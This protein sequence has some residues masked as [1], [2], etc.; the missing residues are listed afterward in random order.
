MKIEKIVFMGTPDFAVPTLKALAD[1]GFKPLLCITQ[2]DRPKGRNR[3]PQA[4]PVKIAAEQLNIPVIQPEDVNSPGMINKLT[5]ISPDIIITVAYGGY[6]KREIR[7]LPAFGCINLHP[8]LLPKYRG[9]APINY[10]L[11]NGDKNTGNTIF[12]IAAKM[13]AGP[14]ISQNKIEIAESDCYTLLY[15]KLSESG[16]QDVVNVLQ[17][18]EQNEII[19]QEQDHTK[20]TFSHKLLK[21]DL[22]INWNNPAGNIRNKV[23]G[24][25]EVPG[26]TASFREKRIKIIEVK[27]L[28][29]L[30]KEHPGSILDISK[31]GIIVNTAD[32][33]MLIKK[34]QPAGKNIMTAHAFSLGARIET[35]EKIEDGF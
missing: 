34:V 15:K 19:F 16:A 1:T 23:R 28:D 24:L 4:T 31:N 25:A 21:D 18:I 17:K 3:K 9:S 27:I 32:K 13:D 11:F 12:R 22:L 35:G 33:N 20:A 2:P 6:L 5:D 8:S 14:V 30:S 7:K 29:N 26:I 10:A